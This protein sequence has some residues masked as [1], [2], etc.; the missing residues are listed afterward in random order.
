[1]DGDG[2]G[3]LVCYLPSRVAFR[4]MDS[5]HNFLQPQQLFFSFIISLGPTAVAEEITTSAGT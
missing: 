3:E 2:D 5:D 4:P 1:M